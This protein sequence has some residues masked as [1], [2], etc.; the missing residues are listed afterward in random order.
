MSSSLYL[1]LAKPERPPSFK[2]A[3]LLGALSYALD[4]TEGQPE[5]HCN[6]LRLDRHPHRRGAGLAR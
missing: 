6:P 3:D 2:L 1:T 5:G 4:M